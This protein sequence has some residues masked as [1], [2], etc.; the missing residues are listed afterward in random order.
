[1]AEPSYSEMLN[2]VLSGNHLTREQA[3]WAF[4]RIMGGEWNEADS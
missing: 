2:N 3:R 1:M 4:G